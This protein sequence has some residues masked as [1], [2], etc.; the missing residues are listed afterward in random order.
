MTTIPSFTPV[1]V[2][3]HAINGTV[4][5]FINGS[6]NAD[7]YL[8]D[9]GD[10]NTSTAESPV[11]T[12]DDPGS[13]MVTL[14]VMNNCESA[15]TTVKVLIPVGIDETLSAINFRAYP[16]PTADVV[17]VELNANVRDLSLQ[18]TDAT[19]RIVEQQTIGRNAG[20][21]RTQLNLEDAASGVYFLRVASSD[22]NF[23][24]RI[25]VQH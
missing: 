12:Y 21:L 23:T 25:T 17:Q 8:W 3:N 14:T 7:T 16:N 13:Y 20:F 22:F 6:T 19:G 15:D 5:T 24:H 9:F 4:V 10:S 2:F 11:H 18:V 1:A